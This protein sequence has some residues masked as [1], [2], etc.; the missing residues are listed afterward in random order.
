MAAAATFGME[1]GGQE[2]EPCRRVGFDCP[3]IIRDDG[4]HE[5]LD[6]LVAEYECYFDGVEPTFGADVL[7]HVGQLPWTPLIVLEGNTGGREAVLSGLF[8]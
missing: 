8:N 2:E 6:R 4:Q 1:I 3:T 7:G 5:P